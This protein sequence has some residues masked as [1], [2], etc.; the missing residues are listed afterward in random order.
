MIKIFGKGTVILKGT[1]IHKSVIIGKNCKIC[2]NVVIREGC[3]IG[4][5]VLIASGVTI[6]T[7]AKIGNNVKIMDNS[8]ITGGMV[9]EDN[10][11]ISCLVATTNDNTMGNRQGRPC[12]APYVVTGA[13]IGAGAILLPGVHIGENAVVAAGA[14]VTKSVPKNTVVMGIP[15]RKVIG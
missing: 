4:D 10:V 13:K 11:F 15:A 8:H 1:D 14:V 2:S 5:N 12:I 7:N 3:T 6:N 9:I